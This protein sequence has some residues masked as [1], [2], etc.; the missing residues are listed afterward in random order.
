MGNEPV[1]T[2]SEIQ[3]FQSLLRMKAIA[4]IVNNSDGEFT[5]HYL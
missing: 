1:I 2:D 4:K 5:A 3:L